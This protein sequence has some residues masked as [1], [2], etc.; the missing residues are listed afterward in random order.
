MCLLQ[1]EIDEMNCL[2]R[3][4][5][6]AD[7]RDEMMRREAEKLQHSDFDMCVCVESSINRSKIVFCTFTIKCTIFKENLKRK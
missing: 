6:E 7:K 5:E 2:I 3:Q 4:K 1:A